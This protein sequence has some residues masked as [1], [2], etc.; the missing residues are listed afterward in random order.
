[1]TAVTLPLLLWCGA[2]TSQTVPGSTVVNDQV[3][4]GDVFATQV[5][6]VVDP[7]QVVAATTALGNGVT[8]TTDGTAVDV[9]SRQRLEGD[10]RASTT[11]NA[12][13]HLGWDVVAITTATGNAGLANTV[14]GGAVTGNFVQKAGE[15]T[16]RAGTGIYG[17]N[18][19]AGDISGAAQ[20][21]V[22][23]QG[24]GASGG[25]TIDASVRQSSAAIAEASTGVHIKYVPG[26]AN[27][28]G[29][30]VNN[31]VTASGA[32]GSRT[33]LD[34]RQSATGDHTQGTVFVSAGTMQSVSAAASAVANNLSA[35]NHGYPAEVSARQTNTSYV[36]AQAVN[37]TDT[38]GASTTLAYG[39]GN[40]VLVGEF[41]PELTLDN[42][43]VNS[44][45][46]AAIAEA[47]GRDGYDMSAQSTAIGNA[48]TG[49]VCSDCGGVINVGNRQVNSSNVVSTT[50]MSLTGAN[51]SVSGISTA[52]GNTAT[53][54]S[55]SPGG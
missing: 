45:G 41:G 35:E 30:T 17:D 46:V 8:V 3:Q 11:L 20:T 12:P 1:M 29:S 26:A 47:G 55:T 50:N 4:L 33:N 28:T 36:R 37:N 7:I 22:N 5:I 24:L 38:F 2:A 6:D 21:V 16:V 52:V 14:N 13:A 9:A 34:V 42:S 32:D 53:F 18:A 27:F 23:S 49:Y 40:S 43:Q 39:V 48:V 31:N 54:Y 15:V 10:V 25:S 19:A 51:R 44:G